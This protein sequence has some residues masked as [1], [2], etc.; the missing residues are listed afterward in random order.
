MLPSNYD[1]TLTA[2][3]TYFSQFTTDDKQT[4]SNSGNSKAKNNV[5][6]I[7]AQIASI[8]PS[9]IT[10]HS[11]AF[12]RGAL[13]EVKA[14]VK[15]SGRLGVIQRPVYGP[16]QKSSATIN[17]EQMFNDLCTDFEHA[18]VEND[19][20]EV[21]ITIK[22]TSYNLSHILPLV[23]YD[24]ISLS[25]EALDE[26]KKLL[27]TNEILYKPA[28]Q[29]QSSPSCGPTEYEAFEA[30]F[31]KNGYVEPADP[32][33][34]LDMAEKLALNV[35]TMDAY[36]IINRVM[37]TQFDQAVQ[38]NRQLSS[39]SMSSNEKFCTTIKEALVHAAVISSALKKLPDYSSQAGSQK[40]V[41][42]VEYDSADFVCRERQ[43]AVA[44]GGTVG[45]C[46]GFLSASHSNPSFL[47]MGKITAGFLIENR[48]GKN[49]SFFSYLPGEKEILFAPSQIQWK[50]AKEGVVKEGVSQKPIFIGQM[51]SSPR[52][53]PSLYDFK[54]MSEYFRSIDP[55]SRQNELLLHPV[56]I[57][58]DFC[59]Y[60]IQTNAQDLLAL[61][62]FFLESDG[63]LELFPALS[64]QT[65]EFLLSYSRN[66][67]LPITNK[68][69]RIHAQ[70]LATV[71]AASQMIHENLLTNNASATIEVIRSFF[72]TIPS[73]DL[74]SYYS[75]PQLR[76]NLLALQ[77]ECEKR[78]TNG[79]LTFSGQDSL[80]RDL[81]TCEECHEALK[82][83][84]VILALFAMEADAT[85][86]L[87][88]L[89]YAE[90]RTI[91]SMIANGIAV[92]HPC[93]LETLPVNGYTRVSED[94]AHIQ[95]YVKRKDIR[96][97]FVPIVEAIDHA[98]VTI[99]QPRPQPTPEKSLFDIPYSLS[100]WSRYRN[101][102]SHIITGIRSQDE[103]TLLD[104]VAK[105]AP[106]T[107]K[108]EVL[109]GFTM[110]CSAE[111][112][113]VNSITLR[114]LIEKMATSD[115]LLD[116]LVSH[117]MY[118]RLHF[119]AALCSDDTINLKG[120][121]VPIRDVLTGLVDFF[122]EQST[123]PL[124]YAIAA[125]Q[126]YCRI[127][128]LA[129]KLSSSMP[130][131]FPHEPL[132]K[133]VEENASEAS[134]RTLEIQQKQAFEMRRELKTLYSNKTIT[135]ILSTEF[136]FN[137]PTIDEIERCDYKTL[138]TYKQEIK[139]LIKENY[140]QF[141]PT[142][143]DDLGRLP[144]EDM[145]A[146]PEAVLRFLQ[147]VPKFYLAHLAESL[148]GE[149]PPGFYSGHC[150]EYEQLADHVL[151]SLSNRPLNVIVD[152]AFLTR[153]GC[154]SLQKIQHL[155]TIELRFSGAGENGLP[156]P[157]KALQSLLSYGLSQK[158]SK[159]WSDNYMQ[160]EPPKELFEL[161]NLKSIQIT[162]HC[163][164]A[165][166]GE[167]SNLSQL[168][169]LSILA[170]RKTPLF[171]PQTLWSMKTIEKLE[172]TSP[173]M[174]IPRQISNLTNLKTLTLQSSAG[175][176]PTL[177]D[178]V[179]SVKN[180]SHLEVENV[181][182]ESIP[183]T[184]SSLK[185]LNYLSIGSPTLSSVSKNLWRVPGLTTL[186]LKTPSLLAIPDGISALTRLETLWIK[187]EH[188]TRE[189][190]TS[191]MSFDC[192]NELGVY[193]T[194]TNKWPEGL[195]Q[196][197]GKTKT[198]GGFSIGSGEFATQRFVP[199]HKKADSGTP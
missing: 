40:Y 174:G 30:Y 51:V 158:V 92:H 139:T 128:F 146:Q 14:F 178:A 38:K 168:Q 39:S 192:L 9:P 80:N 151:R 144:I 79:K 98:C 138:K 4:D 127:M 188:F 76:I 2:P 86:G 117:I 129:E 152:N 121:S 165:I 179:W 64:S 8:Q 1:K 3:N 24:H 11:D 125:E 87:N 198:F 161:T 101:V 83:P 71:S 172:I 56:E 13:E 171:L 123:I 68:L 20:N 19:C 21:T 114:E 100:G 157:Q 191:I 177:S 149:C 27:T 185:N 81:L 31:E 108:T 85:I 65:R 10:L 32:E 196:E 109:R 69:L 113:D 120:G 195:L 164:S 48:K 143:V 36:N 59:A 187:K 175:T 155:N 190:V 112:I 58:A 52:E 33:F 189:I 182:L 199:R 95:A 15:G 148:L 47:S 54:N 99:G 173:L 60:L 26:Y 53:N 160:T 147:F 180:L 141:G 49:I 75:D 12:A 167:F 162:S 150:C 88:T 130:L 176:N 78:F 25:K 193:S 184:V 115:V 77:Q 131:V 23:E 34:R 6:G 66:V 17:A 43:K 91:S 57:Q 18:V 124:T 134:Q 93:V 5:A 145:V 72:K 94:L 159:I 90:G 126:L 35:Y 142:I 156:T 183:D 28:Y 97:T 154:K 70:C 29:G 136:D 44:M 122:A 102:L 62:R 166:P 89:S 67:G 82:D 110:F 96:Q 50:Y 46:L 104:S 55:G 169:E 45:P 132:Q 118:D 119:L 137:P 73:K 116:Q 197:L 133:I 74:Y 153:M 63:I 37:R 181:C 111:K 41:W 107:L 16:I 84:E 105:A 42:R 7:F 186:K 61:P 106:K 22:G 194:D 135:S 103:K 170:F 163:L 140:R